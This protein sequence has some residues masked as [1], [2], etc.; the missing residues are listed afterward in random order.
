MLPIDASPFWIYQEIFDV[1][2]C[3]GK[4]RHPTAQQW[5]PTSTAAD[6][7]TLYREE[8][9]GLLTTA[10]I[11]TNWVPEFFLMFLLMARHA[12][13]L[14]QTICTPMHSKSQHIHTSL[15]LF[16]TLVDTRI[17]PFTRAGNSRSLIVPNKTSPLVQKRFGSNSA[18]KSWVWNLKTT[19]VSVNYEIQLYVNY[20]IQSQLEK[21]HLSQLN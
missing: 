1:L 17:Q 9:V 5:C 10:Y 7:R 8:A 3:V 21:E 16:E 18:L 4:K 13:R 11:F 12:S 14:I 6:E 20:E 15:N 2:H 19:L